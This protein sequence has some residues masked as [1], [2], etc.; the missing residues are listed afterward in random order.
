[1]SERTGIVEERA[2]NRAK[3]AWKRYVAP[4]DRVFRSG[5]VIQPAAPPPIIVAL[6]PVNTIPSRKPTAIMAK[7]CEVYSELSREAF[8]M[9][10]LMSPGRTRK[11]AW[12]R[13]VCMLIVHEATRYSTTVI[14]KAFRRNHTTVIYA[15]I[16]AKHHLTEDALLA[17][18]YA[19]V[20]EFFGVST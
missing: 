20:R 9:G 6:P 18:T 13:H 8:T 3:Y 10:D 2:A 15:L 5:P 1:M 12:A 7:F 14:G 17:L 19:R 11:A 16:A 4:Q